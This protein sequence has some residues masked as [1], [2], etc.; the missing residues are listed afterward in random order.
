MLTAH[1][2]TLRQGQCS[3]PIFYHPCPCWLVS[4]DTYF[5]FC[6]SR[7]SYF[8]FYHYK[9]SYSFM[10]LST[11]LSSHC[12]TT[13]FIVTMFLHFWCFTSCQICCLHFSLLSSPFFVGEGFIYSCF[14]YAKGRSIMQLNPA[15]MDLAV[16]EARR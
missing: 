5:F 6:H 2:T 14:Y 15:K 13:C 7:I 8:V 3:L 12:P 16:S 1:P 11:G 9:I 4:K 10:S